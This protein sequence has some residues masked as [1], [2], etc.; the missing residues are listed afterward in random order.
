MSY[1]H[2]TPVWNPSFMSQETRRL[3]DRLEKMRV[4]NNRGKKSV[5]RIHD[6]VMRLNLKQLIAGIDHEMSV[7]EQALAA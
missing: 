3:R 5:R 4:S 7:A 6:E 2:F 1:R